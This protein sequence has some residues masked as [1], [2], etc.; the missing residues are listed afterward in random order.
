MSKQDLAQQIAFLVYGSA[1]PWR[2]SLLLRRTYR[3]LA[4]QHACIIR[5]INRQRRV[6]Q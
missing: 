1:T 5:R 2:V 3:S 4:R 6:L